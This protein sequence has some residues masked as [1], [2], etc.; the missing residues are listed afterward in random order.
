MGAH[1]HSLSH[2]VNCHYCHLRL[3]INGY[4]VHGLNTH[5]IDEL[6]R[7]DDTVTLTV[8]PRTKAS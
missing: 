8:T 5:Q 3:Q 7:K 1:W 6:L 4:C 2:F